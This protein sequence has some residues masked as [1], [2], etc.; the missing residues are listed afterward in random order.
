MVLPNVDIIS[1]LTSLEIIVCGYILGLLLIFK[2]ARKSTN[3]EKRKTLIIA[4]IGLIGVFHAWFGS[5]TSFLL[6][7]LGLQPLGQLTAVLGYAWGPSLG[8]VM[9]AY[10]AS[11]LIKNGRYKIPITG[12]VTI[13]CIIFFIMV[14]AFPKDFTFY[15]L[16]PEGGL[17]SS[18]FRGPAL[19]ILGLILIIM[20]VFLGPAIIFS[21]YKIEE[22][23]ARWRRLSMGIGVTMASFFGIID[24]AVSDIPLISL[25]IVKAFIF[26]SVF[27]IYEGVDKGN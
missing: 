4:G 19:I 7:S 6:I 8:G 27:L 3:K 24:A 1:G 14:Y 15:N 22:K 5:A 11:N 13:M 17:P 26:T 10:I 20:L 9:W 21:G 2:H 23:G 25:V 18:G 16:S 12:F